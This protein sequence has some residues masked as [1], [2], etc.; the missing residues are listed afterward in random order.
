MAV[1]KQGAPP[2][3]CFA[4]LNVHMRGMRLRGLNRQGKTTLCE[5]QGSGP[6][7]LGRVPSDMQDNTSRKHANG[8]S[9]QTTRSRPISSTSPASASTVWEYRVASEQ[10]HRVET[11]PP[12]AS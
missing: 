8:S 12:Q 4:M 5:Q 1:Q 10:E 9:R 11:N 6:V 7:D 3:A 2:H